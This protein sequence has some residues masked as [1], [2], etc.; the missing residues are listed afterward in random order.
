LGEEV[1]NVTRTGGGWTAYPMARPSVLAGWLPATAETALRVEGARKAVVRALD[2]DDDRLLAV[3]GP[4]SV[5]DK[6]S[7]VA[8]A[9]RL[10]ALAT[11]LSGDLIVVMR[12]YA[13][14]PRTALGWPG[15][16]IDP[17]MDG[18]Y[19]VNRGIALA[20][21]LMLEITAIGLPVACEWLG[22]L[23]PHYLADL[24]TWGAIGARTVE[25]QVHRHLASGLPMPVGFKNSTSGSVDAAVD[26]IRAAS[27]PQAFPGM[28][29][30]GMPA[31]LRTTGNGQC[32]IVLRGGEDGPNYDEQ[33]VMDA[34]TR[35]RAA[36]L[37]ERVVID[38]SHGN[39][40][41]R[42]EQQMVV[43]TDIARR[44]AAGD[45]AIRGVC[46]ESF[47]MPGRQEVPAG[48]L[49]VFGQ[50][51]TDACLGWHDTARVL[52]DLAGAVRARRSTTVDNTQSLA[53]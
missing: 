45:T 30:T 50:S 27:A 40:G 21:R 6:E 12:V 8:Y 3:V 28:D 20:R 7:T 1:S 32:H 17:G 42:H 25:S 24:V 9:R 37:P 15:M 23:A 35:L 46:L 48:R 10:H 4:C 16:L 51:V 29:A 53:G 18:G 41:K 14:K 43:A 34:L 19:Q 31:V 36:G 26:A 52:R 2:G 22:P 5:H 49:P 47:L 13:E 11:E 39:S 38:V 33:S 44:I